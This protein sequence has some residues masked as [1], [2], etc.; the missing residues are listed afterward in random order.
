VND[1]SANPVSW[2]KLKVWGSKVPVGNLSLVYDGREYPMR[3]SAD[4]FWEP[5]GANPGLNPDAQVTV[6]VQCLDGGMSS[7]IETTIRAGSCLCG[8]QDPSCRP[9]QTDIQC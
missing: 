9:C 8:Y 3:R 6:R 7:A 2:P 1:P 4:D 5:L